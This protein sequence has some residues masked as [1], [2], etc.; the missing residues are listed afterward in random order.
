MMRRLPLR[1]IVSY[2]ERLHFLEVVFTCSSAIETAEI[3]KKTDIDLMFL[4]IN[5]PHLTGLVFLESLGKAPM[6]IFTTAY[7]EYA[8]SL[9]D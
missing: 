7:S 8:L 2:I 9:V 4:D 5:M 3:L 1:G 6:T